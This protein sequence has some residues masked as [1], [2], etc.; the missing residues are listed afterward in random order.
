M[1]RMKMSGKKILYGLGI[2]LGASAVGLTLLAARYQAVIRPN[3]MLGEVV[4]GGLTPEAAAKKL[5]LWWEMEKNRPLTFAS[6]TMKKLPS[7]KTPRELGIVVDDIESVRQLPIEEF[8]SYAARTIT[9][10]AP[11]TEAFQVK[12][13]FQGAG[14][15]GLKK[16]VAENAGEPAFARV[17]YRKGTIV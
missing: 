8:G 6:D 5:R 2:V 3:T 7:P 9:R 15:D 12:F 11:E 4:V 13:K 17:S 1:L 16:F 10:S 14:F